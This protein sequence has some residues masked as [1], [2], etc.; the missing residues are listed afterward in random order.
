M[1]DKITKMRDKISEDMK[2]GIRGKLNLK[3]ER[4]KDKRL[5]RFQTMKFLMMLL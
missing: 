2:E 3:K 1:N 4:F 5:M